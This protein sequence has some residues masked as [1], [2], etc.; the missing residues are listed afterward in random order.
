MIISANTPQQ[1][2]DKVA[3]Y[4]DHLKKGDVFLAEK[5]YAAAMFEYEKASDIMPDEEQ[6]KL[7]MQSI[8]ATLGINELAEVKRKVRTGKKLEKEQLE[9]SKVG[10][11]SCNWHTAT[12]S[13]KIH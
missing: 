1:P 4:K 2:V 5:N 7:K 6:P 3:I 8:E 12:R 10:Y 11:H 9:K 13:D